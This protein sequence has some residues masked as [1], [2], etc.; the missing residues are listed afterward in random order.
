MSDRHLDAAGRA[1]YGYM[2]DQALTDVNE[3]AIRSIRAWL[4]SVG[5]TAVE[6]GSWSETLRAENYPSFADVASRLRDAIRAVQP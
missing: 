4:D 5:L 3:V 6:A 2:K 1:A